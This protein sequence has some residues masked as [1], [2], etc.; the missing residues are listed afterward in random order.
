M[1]ISLYLIAVYL[2]MGEGSVGARSK[3]PGTDMSACCETAVS[4]MGSIRQGKLVFTNSV[5]GY[6]HYV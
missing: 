3:H 2:V 4:G 5:T 6:N 1:Y